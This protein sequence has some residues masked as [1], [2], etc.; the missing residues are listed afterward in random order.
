MSPEGNTWYVSGNIDIRLYNIDNNLNQRL[1]AVL[2]A[3]HGKFHQKI[4]VYPAENI[5]G[6]GLVVYLR[7]FSSSLL[8][9]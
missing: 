6:N 7:I 4:F 5:A 1:V 3:L 9:D 8:R 2:C